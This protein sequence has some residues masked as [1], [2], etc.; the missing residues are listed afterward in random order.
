MENPWKKRAYDF[1][2]RRAE[3]DEK[4]KDLLILLDAL[5][6]GQRKHLLRDETCGAILRKYGITE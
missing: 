2:R 5:P 4:A 3:A 6:P 1:N